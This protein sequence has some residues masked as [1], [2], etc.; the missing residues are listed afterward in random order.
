MS[1]KAFVIW[2][3]EVKLSEFLAR[4]IN[5]EIIISCKKYW[6]RFAIP[7][8]LR[9]VIQ[10]FDTYK[11]LKR[12]RPQIIFVQN[13]PITAVLVVYLYAKFNSASYIIDTHTAGFIDRKWIFFHPLHKF[14]AKHALWN[15]A[16]NYKNLEIL[17]K[18]GIK[19]SSVLQFYTPTRPEI[20]KEDVILPEE[21]EEKLQKH[22]GLKVFMVNRFA[23]DDAWQEVAETAR[24]MPEALF[25][26]TGNNQKI[27]TKI[28]SGFPGNV[29]L[30]NYLGHAQFIALMDRADVVLALTKRRDTV[31]WSLREIMALGK[32]VVTTDSETI[33]HYF[34]GVALFTNHESKDLAEKIQLAWKTR[35]ELAEKTKAFL[36]H[37][38][39]RW[40]NDILELEKIINHN[41]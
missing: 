29:V 25:F 21:L 20:L 19:K 34:S 17:K 31:L 36:A 30:T 24:T 2:V 41:G 28:K 11:K 23:S 35:A 26:L 1:K 40:K 33:R 10:G 15:T 8:I 32:P 14:L 27:S 4:E 38:T 37:D 5:A 7:I 13:P 3:Q 18:W 6:G 39:I 12:I 22:A 9:Y 16:H